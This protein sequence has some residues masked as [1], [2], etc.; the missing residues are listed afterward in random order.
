MLMAAGC[1]NVLPA[2]VVKHPKQI[3]VFHCKA[4]DDRE[5]R[6][7]IDRTLSVTMIH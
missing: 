1:A 6:S 2:V 4:R 3:A 7:N 5:I